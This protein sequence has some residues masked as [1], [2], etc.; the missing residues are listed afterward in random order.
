MLEHYYQRLCR[1]FYAFSPSFYSLIFTHR[2]I[3]KYLVAGGM[4]ASVDIGLLYVFTDIFD[5]WY[6]VSAALAFIAAFFVSFVLQKFWTFRDTSTD[7][8]HAQAGLYFVVALLNLCLN[9]ALMYIFVDIF[10]IWY[11]FSQII[12]GLLVASFSFFIYNKFIFSSSR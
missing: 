2:M 4:A 8:I 11:I 1:K 9:T 3:A 6:L 12:I 5:I 7:K 10:Q